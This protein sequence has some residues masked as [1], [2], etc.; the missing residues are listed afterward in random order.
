M[1]VKNVAR[2]AGYGGSGLCLLGFPRSLAELDA[3]PQSFCEPDL[4]A[5]TTA[6]VLRAPQR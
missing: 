6:G 1:I 4:S 3:L 2:V 5:L